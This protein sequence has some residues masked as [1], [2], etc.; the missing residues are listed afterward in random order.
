MSI[1]RYISH[2]QYTMVRSNDYILS[3]TFSL[4]EDKKILTSLSLTC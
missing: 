3:F 4:R 2:K 1:D